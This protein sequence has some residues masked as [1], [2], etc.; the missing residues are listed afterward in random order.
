MTNL[1]TEY[2]R[3]TGAASGSLDETLYVDAGAGTGKTRAL[4]RRIV[5]L[6]L[7]ARLSQKT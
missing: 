3:I 5:S 1:S 2:E 6:L 4:V 7:M